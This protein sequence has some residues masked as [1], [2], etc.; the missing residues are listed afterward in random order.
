M[1]KCPYCGSSAQPVL[2]STQL[3][4]DGWTITAQRKYSCACGCQFNTESFYR[5]DGYEEVVFA[6]EPT[7]VD[8][9]PCPKCGR[10]LEED[11]C[12]DIVA[13]DVGIDGLCV[14]YC[15]T[16]GTGYQWRK[17]YSFEG[18]DEIEECH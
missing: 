4:E 13:T 2:M 1:P 10:A 5:S 14:G 7:I 16:C 11:D 18:F 6:V 3:V 8:A 9:P 15:P 12:F 17:K